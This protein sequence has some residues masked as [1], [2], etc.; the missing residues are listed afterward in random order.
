MQHML[1]V[2]V[3]DEQRQVWAAAVETN[4]GMNIDTTYATGFMICTESGVSMSYFSVYKKSR[5][6]Y[7]AEKSYRYRSKRD[8]CLFVYLFTWF[9]ITISSINPLIGSHILCGLQH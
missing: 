8:S 2:P 4:D 1:F 7:G 6:R 5:S 3:A 9:V